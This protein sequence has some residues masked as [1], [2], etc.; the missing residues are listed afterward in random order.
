MCQLLGLAVLCFTLS[1][2]NG[3][4]ADAS[5]VVSTRARFKLSDIDKR[6]VKQFDSAWRQ[7]GHGTKPFEAV[8]LILRESDGSTEA[9]LAGSSNQSYEFT[10]RWNPAIIAIVH[11][12][13]N[14]RNPKPQ[15]Q[16][17]LVATKFAVPVLT[18]TSFGMFM[19]DPATHQISKIY[20]DLEWLDTSSWARKYHW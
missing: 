15:D 4:Q 10:F 17:I 5:P 14:N 7:C 19:F 8:V 9:F 18:I 6:V 16:D 1:L 20:D 11:T 13:P 2:Q 3:A 12:H